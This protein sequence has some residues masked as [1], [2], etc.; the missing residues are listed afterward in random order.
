MSQPSLRTPTPVLLPPVA[1]GAQGD[2]PLLHL[3]FT[4]SPLYVGV[5]EWLGDDGRY[6]S[7]NPSAALRLGRP[8]DEIRGQRARDLGMPAEACAAWA[9]LA[10]EAERRGTAVRGEWQACT[11]KGVS[12]FCTTVVHLPAPAGSAPRFAFLTEELTGKRALEWRLGGAEALSAAL[13]EDVEQ[14]LAQALDVL[15]VVGDEVETL[16]DIHPDLELEDAV[17]GLRDATRQSRRAHQRLR[18][19]LWG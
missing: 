10:A 7:V 8:I 9:Q 18:E 16:A 17:A 12:S 1:T 5:L 11:P 3:L 15:Q 14:P 13:T 2:D 19:L 6:L 4:Q